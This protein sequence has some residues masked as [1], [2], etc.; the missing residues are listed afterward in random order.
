MNDWAGWLYWAWIGG[1]VWLCVWRWDLFVTPDDLFA[2][3][4]LGL[5]CGAGGIVIG[6]LGLFYGQRGP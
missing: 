5:L 2:W 4:V 3:L 6:M 1:V